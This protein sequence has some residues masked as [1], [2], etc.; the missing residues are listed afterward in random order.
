M[1]TVLYACPFVPPEWI[2]AHG[3]SAQR[4]VPQPLGAGGAGIAAGLCPYAWAFMAAVCSPG[5]GDAVIVTTVCDQMRRTAERI[6]ED[7][8]RAVFL[9]HVPATWEGSAPRAL[10][11]EELKRLGRFLRR[12]GGRPPKAGELVAVMRRHDAAR[13]AVRAEREGM[14]GRQYAEA[15]AGLS[16]TDP[17]RQHG[18]EAAPPKGAPAVAIVGGP[19]M[20]RDLCLFDLIERYGGRVVL[21]ATEGGELTLPAPLDEARLFEAPLAALVESYFGGIPHAFRRPNSLLYQWLGRELPA[22]K[23]RAVVFVR[24]LWCDTWHGEAR[25]LAEWSRLPTLELDLSDVAQDRATGDSERL[26][27]RIQAFMEMLA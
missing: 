9:M 13:A 4:I 24:H 7:T 16:R 23:V 12:L 1:K 21:N 15:I 20:Q 27:G 3:L 8:D 11:T 22:R 2:A 18:D 19:L 5:T 14:T 10:Y 26:G 6:A 17:L 25:R